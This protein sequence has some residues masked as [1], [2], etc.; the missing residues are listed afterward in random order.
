M[1]GSS[2]RTAQP[3]SPG[4]ELISMEY[5]VLCSDFLISRFVRYVSP[6]PTSGVIC[7]LRIFREIACHSQILHA[8]VPESLIKQ[9]R[10]SRIKVVGSGEQCRTRPSEAKRRAAKDMSGGGGCRDST[11]NV[12]IGSED[13][14]SDGVGGDDDMGGAYVSGAHHRQRITL[15]RPAGTAGAVDT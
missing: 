15:S 11:G 13:T 1:I 7:Q 12:G 14:D 8:S 4:W 9:L 5:L 10:I 2:L 6:T 3:T